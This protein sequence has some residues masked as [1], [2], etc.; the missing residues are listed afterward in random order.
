MKF[1][2][3]GL[4]LLAPAAH[5]SE[6][7]LTCTPFKNNSDFTEDVS[8][9]IMSATEIEVNKVKLKKNDDFVARSLEGFKKYDGDTAKASGWADS[10]EVEILYNRKEKRLIMRVRGEVFSTDSFSCK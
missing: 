7:N 6:E 3:L 9:A 10:G 1:L 2:F 8:L 4:V 5:A